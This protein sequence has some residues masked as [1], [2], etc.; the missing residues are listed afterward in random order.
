M[1]EAI[2]AAE[3]LAPEHLELLIERPGEAAAKIRSAGAIFLGPWSPASFG[4]YLAGPNHILPTGGAARFASPLGVLDF[5]KWTSEVEL[6]EEAAARLSEPAA[7]LAELEGF[8]AHAR[9]L[10]LRGGKG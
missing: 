5:I 9:S 3:R 1:E 6:G 4:D 8:P 7:R 2:E 10:R